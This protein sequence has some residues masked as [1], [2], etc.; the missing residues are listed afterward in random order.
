MRWPG[1]FKI[2]N[3]ETL[4]ELKRVRFELTKYDEQKATHGLPSIQMIE[5]VGD[6]DALWIIISDYKIVITLKND[7]KLIYEILSG[8][9]YDDASTP[10]GR[11]NLL[12]SLRAVLPH[13]LNFSCRYLSRWSKYGDNGFRATNKLFL[14]MLYYAIE[15]EEMAMLE[16]VKSKKQ[17][18]GK[19]TLRQRWQ[20]WRE[21]RAVKRTTRQKRRKARVYFVAVSSIVGRAYYETNRRALHSIKSKFYYVKRGTK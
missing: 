19:L 15:Q 13:D 7:D 5:E 1:G 20:F 6:L 2:K 12:M 16:L 18:A 4:G 10:V 9:V 21:E 8:L 3:I 17:A 14:Y 11:N